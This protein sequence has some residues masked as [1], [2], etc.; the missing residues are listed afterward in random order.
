MARQVLHVE[1]TPEAA[2]GL[3]KARQRLGMTKVALIS[4]LCEWLARQP[5]EIVAL[6]V[7]T[8]PDSIRSDVAKLALKRL[9]SIPADLAGGR[10]A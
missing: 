5:P 10:M 7:G 8:I 2:A 4:R 3:V 9:E 1:I 6:T